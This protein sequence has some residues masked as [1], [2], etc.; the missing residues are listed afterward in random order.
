M[1]VTARDP[2]NVASDLDH[3]LRALGSTIPVLRL[4]GAAVNPYAGVAPHAEVLERTG[5]INPV[6]QVRIIKFEAVTTTNLSLRS[7]SLRND[8]L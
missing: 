7:R 4:P 3:L 5:R 8:T 6:D 2:V 1:L